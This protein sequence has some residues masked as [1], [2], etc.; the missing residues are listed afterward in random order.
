M[1][2]LPHTGHPECRPSHRSSSI[3]FFH[4]AMVSVSWRSISL[5][6]S[7]PIPCTRSISCSFGPPQW[8][9]RSK[10]QGGQRKDAGTWT[11]G[12]LELL[13]VLWLT[14]DFQ[15]SLRNLYLRP[16]RSTNSLTTDPTGSDTGS[17]LASWPEEIRLAGPD[18]TS[19]S[20]SL[21]LE[22]VIFGRLRQ[23]SSH[24]PRTSLTWSGHQ[25]VRNSKGGNTTERNQ[26]GESKH[27]ITK[28]PPST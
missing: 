28:P 10:H 5:S 27:Y 12:F 7:C 14:K 2:K 23:S 24:P 18:L 25:E 1:L 21:P 3:S 20:R 26:K 8:S 22:L 19:T 13:E 11:S 9:L 6:A 16:C 4:L 15:D 17:A